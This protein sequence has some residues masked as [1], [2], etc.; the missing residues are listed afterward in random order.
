[1]ILPGIYLTHNGLLTVGQREVAATLHAG[2]GS[3]ISGRAA[4]AR[5]GIRV[6]QSDLV[7]VLI[8]HDRIRMSAEFVQV[9]R[10]KRMPAQT[11]RMDGLL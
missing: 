5:Q 7:D 6:P 10:T 11:W 3:V 4:L 9:H 1:M 2:A 8:P